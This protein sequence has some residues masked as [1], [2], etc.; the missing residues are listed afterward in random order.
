M[1]LSSLPMDILI[2]LRTFSGG[3]Y[4]ILTSRDD[5][6]VLMSIPTLKRAMEMT[7]KLA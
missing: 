6:D 5:S 4:Y 1:F 3:L 2:A 7:Y